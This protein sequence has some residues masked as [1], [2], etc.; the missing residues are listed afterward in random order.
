M[1]PLELEVTAFGPYRGRQVVDFALLGG[2]DLFLIH[3]PTGAGKTS[4]FDAIVFALYGEVPG[5]RG[6]QPR[7]KSDLAPPEEAPRA[8]FRFALGD[9]VYTV[10][11]TAAFTRPARRGHGEVDQ[12]PTASLRR[13]RDGAVLATRA[14]A[15]TEQIEEL[16]GFD[17]A[18]F[19][20]VV[21]LP[22][23]E[24]KRLL[25]ADSRERE[26]LLKKLFGTEDYEQVANLLERRAQALGQ[27]R[28][29][30]DT[31]WREQLGDEEPAALAARAEEG[32]GALA[33]ARAEAARR[34]AEDALSERALREA[35]ALA[36][37]FGRLDAA[38]GALARLEA[39]RDGLLADEARLEAARRAE[40]VR[41]ELERGAEAA[42]AERERLEGLGAAGRAEEAAAAALA[43]ARK[44]LAGA[45]A[46]GP[47][48]EALRARAA[49]L[50]LAVEPFQRRA[51]AIAA[52]DGT[53]AEVAR[54][55]AER[56]ERARQVTE[57]ERRL[58]EADRRLE[59]LRPIAA[60][61]GE[62]AQALAAAERA[63]DVARERAEAAERARE[64]AAALERAQAAASAASAAS[65]SAEEAARALSRA[66]EAGMAAWFAGKLAPGHACPVC[67]ATE[68]PAKATGALVARERVDEAERAAAALRARATEQGAAAARAAA[69]RDEAQARLAALADCGAADA[70]RKAKE[71]AGRRVLLARSAAAEMESASAARQKLAA[72]LQGARPQLAAA[73]AALG[74]A[75]EALAAAAAALEALARQAG[76]AGVAG[77]P[78][79]ELAEAR[80]RL[81]ALESAARRAVRTEGEAAAA[82][83]AASSRRGA[84]EGELEA[85]RAR[86]ARA[87]AALEEACRGA[88]FGS[89]EAV[90]AALLD[91]AALAALEG[92]VR[93][94]REQQAAAASAAGELEAALEGLLRPDLAAARARRDEA[95]AALAGARERCGALER[96]REAVAA[97]RARL[98]EL[99]RE[100]AAVEERLA[101]ARRLADVCSGRLRGS[102]NLSLQ[103]YVLAA[104]MEEVAEA[105][106]RRLLVMSRGRYRFR[107]DA[108]KARANAAAGLSLLVEDGWTGHD[109]AVGALSGGESFL[110]S[111]SLALGLSDVVLARSGGRR[112]D[113]LFVDE[114]FGSLDEETLDQ[115]LQALDELRAA[116]RMVG[117]ISHVEELKRRIPARVEVLKGQQGS[118][119]VVR[120]G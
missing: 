93:S 74:A 116:R 112:L 103:R 8:R 23:G 26:D 75:R 90:R 69:E 38:R 5:S 113:A 56:D 87:A 14:G 101:V 77:D 61:G 16:L 72:R 34:E 54:R 25:L 32:E 21:L 70:L 68:H 105:A 91:A 108:A 92:S 86:R 43:A 71:E 60:A 17:A 57:A 110:A 63:L 49:R 111:L 1:R 118:T 10:E 88:G 89:G 40:G 114:G 33:A 7:L 83:A 115:A 97:R 2:S 96:E 15:V 28:A 22:Q 81:A 107:H 65:S 94:R 109:R 53:E 30:L 42:R 35:E 106:S 3:G 37:R 24:F 80:E 27:E 52:R 47:E 102:L 58:G 19:T 20:Q 31:R 73:E 117:I 18:Q 51:A 9:E 13:E 76:E 98:D 62:A 67:G 85:A 99:A 11:R 66:R 4:L 119:V 100:R 6:A 104:R 64:R 39:A 82:L 59:E 44:E 84:A 78:R 50:E 45:E 36:E 79:P 55:A 95:R 29:V 12:A 41:A 46:A 48:R 120:A